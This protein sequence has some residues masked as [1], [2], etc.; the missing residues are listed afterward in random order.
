[1]SR[2]GLDDVLGYLGLKRRPPGP[3]DALEDAL[4]V[5]AI[6]RRAAS[7]GRTTNNP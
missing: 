2:C 4:A 3:H 5:A 6:V 1:M 7:K